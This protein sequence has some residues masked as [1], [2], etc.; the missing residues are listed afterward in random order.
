MRQ[1]PP[2]VVSNWREVQLPHLIRSGRLF[3]ECGLAALGELAPLLLVGDGQDQALATQQPQHRGLG[4][5]MA[6]VA[7]HRPHLAVTPRRVRQ[8]MRDRQ[9]RGSTGC[10]SRPRT[11]RPIA[12]EGFGPPAPPGPF[13]HVDQV[14]RTS[15]STFPLSTTVQY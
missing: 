12:T 9:V 14:R 15:K 13:G 7:D 6:A 4:D 1:V 3:R 11:P 2:A 8:P 5:D 10:R